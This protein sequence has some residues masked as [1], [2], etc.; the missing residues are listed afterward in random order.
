AR[1]AATEAST[2]RRAAPR[3]RLLVRARRLRD[4]NASLR[5]LPARNVVHLH[6]LSTGGGPIRRYRPR[7]ASLRIGAANGLRISGTRRPLCARADAGGPYG[8]VGV[9]RFTCIR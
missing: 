3:F 4:E 1:S 7:P 2:A 5:G 8:G 9:G 6:T